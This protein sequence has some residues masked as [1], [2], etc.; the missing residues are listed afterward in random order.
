MYK[1]TEMEYTLFLYDININKN[2][3]KKVFQTSSIRI[4]TRIS[5]RISNFNFMQLIV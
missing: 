4:S 5:S 3:L 1:I 2:Y